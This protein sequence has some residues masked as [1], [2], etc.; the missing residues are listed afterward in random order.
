M[1][2]NLSSMTT[3][4]RKQHKSDRFS[5]KTTTLHVYHTFLYISLPSLHDYNVKRPN[6]MRRL[7]RIFLC[8]RELVHSSLECNCRKICR[9]L[10]NWA[11][12]NN[13][14]KWRFRC[15]FPLLRNF[16]VRAHVNF[17]RV[18]IIE[19]MCK[20]PRLNGKVDRGSTF[21]FTRDLPY[22]SCIIFTRVKFSAYAW[23]NYATVEIHPYGA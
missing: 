7:R 19:V 3:G 23:K 1:L 6:W 15:W 2:E 17:T 11:S 8:H 18:N 21:T 4:Q 16:T 5:C 13:R 12:G 14:G 20:R 10:T 22:M 9:Y